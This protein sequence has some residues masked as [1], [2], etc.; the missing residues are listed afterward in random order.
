M[1]IIK[2][3][4]LGMIVFTCII[5]FSCSKSVDELSLC[6][7]STSDF[8]TL[9]QNMINNGYTEKVT[10]DTEIHE[11]TFEVSADKE[12]CKIGYQS[13]PDIASTA[14]V[15]ELIDNSSNTTIYS[16]SHV[17]SSTNTSYV[18][19]TSTV[20]LQ[21][22]IS[23]TIRRIQTNWGPYISYTV[24]RIARN[25]TMDFPYSNGVLTITSA[26]FYQ[27]GGPIL[28]AAVPYIDLILK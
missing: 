14:Y 18:A 2:S 11:Y 17:F 9:F 24:G 12:I 28:D 27:N 10:F 16:D 13:D 19:P 15:I 3:S 4:F 23:Y 26:N 7:S 20:I 6:D 8:Q 5:Q 25:T 22:G 1:K 21:S